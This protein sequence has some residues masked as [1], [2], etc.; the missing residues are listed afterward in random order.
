MKDKPIG[1]YLGNGKVL[2]NNLGL[3]V[4]IFNNIKPVEVIIE[5][6]LIKRINKQLNKNKS[7]CH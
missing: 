3:E 4:F 2:L 7:K 5:E 6:K 1:T